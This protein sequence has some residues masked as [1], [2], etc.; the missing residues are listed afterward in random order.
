MIACVDGAQYHAKL[1]VDDIVQLLSALS[2]FGDRAD[3]ISGG[4][5]SVNAL[6]TEVGE[7]AKQ[8]LAAMH[9]KHMESLNRLLDAEQWRQ[10]EVC[11]A[12][13]RPRGDEASWCV[14]RRP[15]LRATVC[16]GPC[17]GAEH[18]GHDIQ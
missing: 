2:H 7:Q 9:A 12:R 5:G 18:R 11:C 16:A 4:G 10:A 15:C 14:T 6:R 8:Y 3:S 17:G 13:D 1:K